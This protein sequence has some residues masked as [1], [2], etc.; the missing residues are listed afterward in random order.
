MF[1]EEVTVMDAAV[2]V[3][4]MESSMQSAALISADNCL[5]SSFPSDAMMEYQ[6]QSKQWRIKIKKK[7]SLFLLFIFFLVDLVLKRLGLE[8]LLNS[9]MKRMEEIAALQI[10]NCDADPFEFRKDLVCSET[11]IAQTQAILANIHIQ[12]QEKSDLFVN[13]ENECGVKRKQ[14][15]D[16]QSQ[17]SKK[18]RFSK[19]KI[20]SSSRSKEKTFDCTAASTTEYDNG[21]LLKAVNVNEKDTEM[22]TNVCPEMSTSFPDPKNDSCEEIPS[23]IGSPII[24][25]TF[26]ENTNSSTRTKLSIFKYSHGDGSDDDTIVDL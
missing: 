21:S 8:E 25:S 11:H 4:L 13:E 24:S 14:F 26:K 1:R 5:H 18:I 6:R 3:T 22:L 20:C 12:N 7:K 16:G 10:E 9:E 23:I 17:P 19:E 2:V 15:D